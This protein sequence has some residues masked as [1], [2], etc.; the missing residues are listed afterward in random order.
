MEKP[1]EGA[2]RIQLFHWNDRGEGG[3]EDGE[4]LGGNP[5]PDNQAL[6]GL[7]GRALAQLTA[8]HADWGLRQGPIP[9]S[10]GHHP[11]LHLRRFALG[12]QVIICRDRPG[13]LMQ[14]QCQHRPP[15]AFCEPLDPRQEMLDLCGIGTEA[16]GSLQA[17]LIVGSPRQT[18][19]IRGKRAPSAMPATSAAP[20]RR[21]WT[22]AAA[23]YHKGQ[24]G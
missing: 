5:V 17:G 19:S 4:A 23:A 18:G 2:S 11:R 14:M 7:I 10:P 16:G 20:A 22:N 21:V 8:R 3:V 13:Y 6:N 1:L 24:T 12:P 15:L 9:A